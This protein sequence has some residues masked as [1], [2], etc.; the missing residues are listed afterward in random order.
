MVWQKNLTIWHYNER[1]RL[2]FR[3]ASRTRVTGRRQEENVPCAGYKR[4]AKTA[5]EAKKLHTDRRK[6]LQSALSARYFV[7]GK[8]VLKV[9][10]Q[11]LCHLSGVK[12]SIVLFG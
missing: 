10:K 4:I 7:K 1:V 11:R 6:S 12:Q 3:F 5:K 2:P 9:C 8:S